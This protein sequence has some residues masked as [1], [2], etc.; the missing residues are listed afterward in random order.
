M[1]VLQDVLE[2]WL[3]ASSAGYT[4]FCNGMLLQDVSLSYNGMLL[5]QDASF[6]LSA[7]VA[8]VEEGNL[9]G[10]E[11]LFSVAQNIDVNMANKVYKGFLYTLYTY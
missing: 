5:L 4:V 1:L 6:V 2:L 11:K 10:L 9:P 3:Y 7:M 8:A